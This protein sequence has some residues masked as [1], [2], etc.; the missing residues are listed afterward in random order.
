M[1]PSTPSS[2]PNPLLDEARHLRLKKRFAQ[3]FLIDEA[4]LEHIVETAAPQPDET[5]LE[6]GPGSGFL[7]QKLLKKSGQVVAVELERH[8]A[9]YLRQKFE[10]TSNLYIVESDI[11]KLDFTQ[12]PLA[13][14][15]PI[16]I[17]GN[18]PYNISTPILFMLA[19]ELDQAEH[20]L[21]GRISKAILMVQKEVGERICAHP[22]S[23]AFNALSVAVQYWFSTELNFIVPARAF[24]PPPKVESAVVTITP[25]KQ[26]LVPVKDLAVFSR[27][28]KTA[29]SQRRKTLKNALAA[30][31]EPAVLDKIL[32]SV[33][34]TYGPVRGLRAEALSI[35]TMGALADAYV[36]YTR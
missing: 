3:H 20:P 2:V 18:L 12:P 31:A 11:L 16:K 14:I 27:L 1:K 33:E 17:V 25:R 32:S 21:R 4:V 24:Y 34:A 29:F 22:G 30:F 26:P 36:E 23:K 10:A 13:E 7:T 5:V 28:V 9:A 6:I 35:E 8:I 15:N 19:G